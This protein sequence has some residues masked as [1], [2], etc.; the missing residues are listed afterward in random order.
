LKQDH[1]DKVSV[2]HI[3]NKSNK[4]LRVSRAFADFLSHEHKMAIGCELNRVGEK[5]YYWKR[6]HEVSLSEDP[7]VLDFVKS[8]FSWRI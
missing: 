6:E 4:G 2:A 1:F 5:E 7:F 8:P 3:F